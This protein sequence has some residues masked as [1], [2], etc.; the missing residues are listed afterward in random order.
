MENR[1]G[2]SWL[3]AIARQINREKGEKGEKGEKRGVGPRDIRRWSFASNSYRREFLSENFHASLPSS[4][5][6]ASAE[7]KNKK[8][9]A[10]EKEREEG[11]RVI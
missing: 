7:G 8:A 3:A 6:C 10:R 1:G 4:R 9:R 5:G 11:G 2:I